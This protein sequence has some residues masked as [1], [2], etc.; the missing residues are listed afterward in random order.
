MTAVR[1]GPTSI[2][3]SW[4]PSSNATGYRID[5]D[6]SG[7]GGGSVS[8]SGGSTDNETLTGLQNGDTYT[9][10]IVATSEL[11]PSESVAA[12]MSV[13]L[14]ESKC[15]YFILPFSMEVYDVQFQTH[16]LSVQT[17]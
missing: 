1:D 17:P 3:V 6:I 7:G 4:S 14:C 12:D 8:V 13:G 2:L 5:Y 16:Q 15:I 11:L 9:I 10:S